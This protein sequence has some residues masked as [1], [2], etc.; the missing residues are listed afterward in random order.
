[1]TRES[2]PAD[3]AVAIDHQSPSRLV[4]VR[5]HGTRFVR[6]KGEPW[7]MS[8]ALKENNRARRRLLSGPT[9]AV[10]AWTDYVFSVLTRLIEARARWRRADPPRAHRASRTGFVLGG[11]LVVAIVTILERAL[12]G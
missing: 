4:Q 1:M 2:Q 5:M 9:P 3:T 6:A 8:T 12:S 10:L 7:N 11:G